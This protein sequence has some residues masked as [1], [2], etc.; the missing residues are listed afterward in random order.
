MI[1]IIIAVIAGFFAF[2]SFIKYFVLAPFVG[3]VFGF[4]AWLM[5]CIF[6]F[7]IFNLQS[8]CYFL[9]AGIVFA[10]VGAAT[11]D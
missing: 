7:D 6:N 9:I 1:Y 3:I 11:S 8:F 4:M 5:V 10:E 2:P